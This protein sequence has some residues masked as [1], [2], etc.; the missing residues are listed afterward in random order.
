MKPP[1]LLLP[2]IKQEISGVPII[3]LINNKSTFAALIDTGADHSILDSRL[4]KK[5]GLQVKPAHELSLLC[6]NDET[7][8]TIGKAELNVQIG[9]KPTSHSFYVL[10]KLALPCII[11]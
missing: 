4:V 10:E 6:A 3:S 11:G 8:N 2:L 5:L 1:S 9:D 7:I